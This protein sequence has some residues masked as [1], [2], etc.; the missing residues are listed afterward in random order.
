MNP[1]QKNR[2]LSEI[3]FKIL[4]DLHRDLYIDFGDFLV[5]GQATKFGRLYLRA[6]MELEGVLGRKEYLLDLIKAL[7]PTGGAENALQS[8]ETKCIII[9]LNI[10][11]WRIPTFCGYTLERVIP[12]GCSPVPP[13]VFSF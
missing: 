8:R 9:F 2:I 13:V 4:R 11:R 3:L 12:S 10:S 5:S 6:Q 1:Y 7:E